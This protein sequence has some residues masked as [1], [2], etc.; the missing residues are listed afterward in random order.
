M[1]PKAKPV[2]ESARPG[3]VTPLR[4]RSSDRTPDRSSPRR[5]RIVALSEQGRILV[6]IGGSVVPAAISTSAC[7]TELLA[8]VRASAEVLVLFVDDDPAQP[9]I[10]GL[11]RDRLVLDESTER[12]PIARSLDFGATSAIRLRAGEA[13]MELSADGR[14]EIRGLEVV[15]VAEGTNQ[16]IGGSVKI[17]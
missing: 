16:V 2:P 17:N 1:R 13:S 12:M 11:L 14:V 7:E 5:A 9:V 15:S 6:D 10:V 4:A 3:N 8:A